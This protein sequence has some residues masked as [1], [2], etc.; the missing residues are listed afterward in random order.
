MPLFSK[1]RL[2]LILLFGL[3][4]GTCPLPAD[5]AFDCKI[6]KLG[7][8]GTFNVSGLDFGVS[9]YQSSWVG[10]HQDVFKLDPGFPKE[11]P[12]SWEGKLMLQPGDGAPIVLHEKL[13]R[14]TDSS[15]KCSY[16]AEGANGSPLKVPN[17]LAFEVHL[18]AAAFAGKSLQVDD[19][20]VELP[21]TAGKNSIFDKWGAQKVTL[22]LNGGTLTIE[23]DL[24]VHVQDDRVYHQ[25]YFLFWIVIAKSD[26]PGDPVDLALTISY[27]PTASAAK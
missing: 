10:V 5:P 8:T 20:A 6:V 21:A 11:T 15:F 9:V 1:T 16:R 13:E 3:S 24:K 4:I 17:L 18:P 2:L 7:P 12:A 19:Q 23:G 14:A 27:Q 25:D 22:P 26:T